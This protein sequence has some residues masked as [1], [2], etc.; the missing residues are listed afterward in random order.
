MT[1]SA[2]TTKL[3][4]AGT[5]A[6]LLIELLKFATVVTRPMKATVAAHH[7]LSVNE[8]RMLMCLSGEG[9]LAGQEIAGLMSMAPMNVSRALARLEALGWIERVEDGHDRRRQPV[10]LSKA[11]WKAYNSI[12]P[13]IRETARWLFAPLAGA[14]RRKM[15]AMIAKLN[16][17]IEAWG[18]EEEDVSRGRR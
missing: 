10:Q 2:D 17:R 7:D 4:L 8:L 13:D 9:A 16:A 14:D 1:R 12:L 5:D 11:G 15:L 6:Q 18:E 3:G